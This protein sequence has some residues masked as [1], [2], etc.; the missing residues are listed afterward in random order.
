MVRII[1]SVI[2]ALHGLIHLLGFVVY[3]K[4]AEVKDLPYKTTIFAG[5]INLGESGIKVIGILWMLAA[6]GFVVSTV[7]VFGLTGWWQAVTLYVTIFSLLVTVSGIPD[8]VF[9]AAVN[10]IILA[11]LILA[12]KLSFI[13]LPE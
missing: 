11:Y 7:G 3:L 13:P 2:L 5:R 9:G 6:L 12:P 10:V 8:S 4:I 1:V